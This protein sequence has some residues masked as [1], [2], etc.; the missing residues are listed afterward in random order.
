MISKA[1]KEYLKNIYTLIKQNQSSVRV[2]D[3]AEKMHCSKPSVNKALH[4]LKNERARRLSLLWD[5][6]THK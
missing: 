2:T 4:I 5:N 3:I 1:H 6:R